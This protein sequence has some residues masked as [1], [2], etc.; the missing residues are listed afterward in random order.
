[1]REIKADGGTYPATIQD[2][3]AVGLVGFDGLRSETC[4][5]RMEL[6]DCGCHGSMGGRRGWF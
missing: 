6:E 4:G 3:F 5:T 1:M 2:E